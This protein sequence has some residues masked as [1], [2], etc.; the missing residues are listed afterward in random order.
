MTVVVAPVRAG[1][2]DLVHE[3]RLAYL[4]WYIRQYISLPPECTAFTYEEGELSPENRGKAAEAHSCKAHGGHG[5]IRLAPAWRDAD[6]KQLCALLAHELKHMDGTGHTNDPHDL[7]Y[8]GPGKWDPRW[9]PCDR[10]GA[11]VRELR[12][13]I[14]IMD[15]AESN[16][17]AA[18]SRRRRARVTRR[19]RRLSARRRELE[20]VVGPGWPYS[21]REP[22]ADLPPKPFG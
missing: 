16:R 12:A 15:D 6:Q 9:A 4:D 1:S 13:L 7:M 17:E 14:S 5:Y 18:A 20:A 22:A 10:I 19:I 8:G 2:L 11:A 21:A 3:P